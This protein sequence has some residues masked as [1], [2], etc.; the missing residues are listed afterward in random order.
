MI[1]PC[2][3]DEEDETGLDRSVDRPVIDERW[4]LLWGF[5]GE[6]N[7]AKIQVVVFK[8]LVFRMNRYCR[9]VLQ[10]RDACRTERRL[11]GGKWIPPFRR[12][13]FRARGS[14]GDGT[15][16]FGREARLNV[17]R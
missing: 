2:S 11:S 16:V 9:I 4:H 8:L 3:A 7:G 1:D 12:A 15:S 13:P 10:R 6:S 17:L 14:A 5:I